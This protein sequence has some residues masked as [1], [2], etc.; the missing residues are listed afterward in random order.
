M[1]NIQYNY[2]YY[3]LLTIMM[4][5]CMLFFFRIFNNEEKLEQFYSLLG[6]HG[7]YY[8]TFNSFKD[9]FVKYFNSG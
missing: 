4:F 9:Y 6:I 3:M 5:N 7:E 1:Y 8:E 2:T